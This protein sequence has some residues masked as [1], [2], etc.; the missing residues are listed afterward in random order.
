[1]IVAVTGGRHVDP[2]PR[3]LVALGREL[4]RRGA[5][6]LRVGDCP[7]GVDASVLEWAQALPLGLELDQRAWIWEQWR[8][9]WGRHEQPGG[10]RN[11]A[12]P[13]RNRGMLE[14][15]ASGCLD[16]LSASGL[17]SVGR[18]EVLFAW[19]G[20]PGTASACREAERLGIEIVEA[21]ALG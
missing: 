2:R 5:R 17:L 1:V 10:R 7:T 11:P 18:V 20:G 19:P 15:D 21:G 12:G 9:D 3:E 13:I 4:R 6:V 8:A 16:V 14:G